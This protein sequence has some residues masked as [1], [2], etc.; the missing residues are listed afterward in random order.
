M[1]VFYTQEQLSSLNRKNI[2]RHVAIIPDGNRRWASLQKQDAA[3]G[4][5]T[6]CDILLDIVEAASDIDVEYLTLYTFSTDNWKRSKFEVDTLMAL[7][8]VYLT[9]QLPRMIDKGVKL[10]T[11]GDLTP[12]PEDIKEVVHKCKE[13]TQNCDKI[14]LILALNYGSREEITRAFKKILSEVEQGKL[15]KGAVNEEMVSRYLDT[16][17]FPDPELLIRTSGEKRISNYLLWQLSYSE[18]YLTD[19]YWPEFRP[20]DFLEAIMDYQKRERRM[21]GS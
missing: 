5:K 12:L 15:D 2:P 3:F 7:L 10:L 21:G 14:H 17:Q 6:G 16:S 20:N 9:D 19:T 18:I 11:I 13:A 1:S 4:H 8:K